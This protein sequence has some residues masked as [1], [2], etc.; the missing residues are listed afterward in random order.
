MAILASLIAQQTLAE[1]R[2]M[3]GGALNVGVTPVEAKEI[4]YHSVPYVG[5]A[6]AFEFLHATNEVLASRGVELPLPGQSTTTHDGPVREGARAPEVDL[7]R[8]DR[9]DVRAGAAERQIHYPAVPQSA[10]CFGDWQ[11]RTGLDVKTRELADVRRSSSRSVDASRSSRGTSRATS[12]SATTSRFCSRVVTQLLPFIGYPRALNAIACLNEVLRKRPD[13][14]RGA[15]TNGGF[16]RTLTLPRKA[17]TPAF[18]SIA[19][20]ASVGFPMRPHG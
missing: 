19:T 3:L 5:I 1:Y 18:H 16:G 15:S 11:T 13:R 4:L 20:T 7:R 14:Q 10:N 6:K 17:G 2:V 8:P 9:P 12:T